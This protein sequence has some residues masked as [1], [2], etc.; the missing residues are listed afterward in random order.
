MRKMVLAVCAGGLLL[1]APLLSATAGVYVYVD[2]EGTT[3]FTDA[4]TKPHYRPL[5]ALGLP[6]GANLAR[7]QYADLINGIA[8]GHGVD[9]ALVKAIIRAESA[10]DE[11]AVSRKGAQGL[12]QLM[13]G[14]A[15]RYAVGN[16]FDPA[17][18][19]RGG[20]QYLRYLQD[21]FPGQLHLAVAAYNAGENAVLRYGGIPPYPETREYVTRVIR[22]YGQGEPP[23]AANGFAAPRPAAG[24]KPQPAA[25]TPPAPGGVYRQVGADG[26][27]FYTNVP[28]V[29]RSP[30]AP[31]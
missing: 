20:V 31:R 17:D 3:H 25:A 16:S 15:D 6:R 7:G 8:L 21:L 14:T 18:N 22:F 2:P 28:P 5:P 30:Q 12:M 23:A 11:R 24:R 27:P 4:P 9:P 19:I 29:V 10:F 26:V 1:T 13:P